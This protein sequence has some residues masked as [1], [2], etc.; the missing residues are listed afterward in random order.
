ML[1][2]SNQTNFQNLDVLVGELLKLPVIPLKDANS[3]RVKTKNTLTILQQE[4]AIFNKDLPF[5][6]VA[7]RGIETCVFVIFA[8]PDGKTLITHYDGVQGYDWNRYLSNYKHCE[9]SL[10]LIGGLENKGLENIKKVLKALQS[11]SQTNNLTFK[12]THQRV[13]DSFFLENS[14]KIYELNNYLLKKI[15]EALGHHLGKEL[16]EDCSDLVFPA[17]FQGTKLDIY[18]QLVIATKGVPFTHVPR[19][20]QTNNQ[21]WMQVQD[22]I[23][24]LLMLF[25]AVP[26]KVS[27]VDSEHPS[28]AVSKLLMKTPKLI[29]ML[30][31]M[32]FKDPIA[33]Q[34][35]R[36]FFEYAAGERRSY[37][38][39][40]ALSLKTGELCVLP[41][42]CSIGSSRLVRL[43]RTISTPL[44]TKAN[45]TYYDLNADGI[46]ENQQISETV[47]Q[48]LFRFV[49]HFELG[50]PYI[51]KSVSD[52]I[53]KDFVVAQGSA[54]FMHI[55][56]I[57][58]EVSRNEGFKEF[59][60]KPS[61]T[62]PAS[63]SSSSSSGSS[64]PAIKSS[65]FGT[66]QTSNQKTAQAAAPNSPDPSDS[67]F[68]ISKHTNFQW[69][70]LMLSEL[71]MLP[72]TPI[73]NINYH[74]VK[75]A[76]TLTILQ[77]ET[78]I[79]DQDSSF[80]F[81]ATRELSTCIFII[82]ALPDG[83]TLVTHYDGGKEYNWNQYLSAYKN[84]KINLQIVGGLESNGLLNIKKLLV[85][86][87]VLSK[88][89][90]L[91]FE[92]TQQRVQDNFYSEPSLL[93]YEINNFLLHKIRD[94][95]EYYFDS[96]LPENC[97]GL[98]F[99]QHFQD[100][101]V[102]VYGK[103]IQ[104]TAGSPYSNELIHRIRT[105]LPK[106][107]FTVF[108]K[109]LFD[110]R[111]KKG[112]ESEQEKAVDAKVKAMLKTPDNFLA[113]L[114]QRLFSSPLAFQTARI[115]FAYASGSDET[116]YSDVAVSLT[117]GK[118]CVPPHHQCSV[119]SNRLIRL[120]QPL[121]ARF[122]ARSNYV[123]YD[124]G[125]D[126]IPEASQVPTE[127]REMLFKYIPHF[128]QKNIPIPKAIY[129][130]IV[131]DF[132]FEDNSLASMAILSLF[133]EVSR[134]EGFKEFRQQP[135]PADSQ[136]STKEGKEESTAEDK[137]DSTVTAGGLGFSK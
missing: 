78:A 21:L 121:A 24:I 111:P 72:V 79:F 112:F 91:V 66:T 11:L 22:Q 123:Y 43:L 68:V 127:L 76:N 96:G 51:P 124:F 102:S 113:L 98:A 58:S 131:Q 15:E 64:N 67:M 23:G 5:E 114:K 133:A 33:Y 100:S 88:S 108:L 17:N 134:D 59:R 73:N 117:T 104:A 10:Q 53:V 105:V 29:E 136:S 28:D 60:Q 83:K 18:E 46:P 40:A 109:T 93:I 128:A 107:D 2:I 95:L 69:I 82:F 3:E 1:I 41:H 34:V 80:K 116:Y 13:Q 4:T 90:N 31:R 50:N 125:K 30:K 110:I 38:S 75:T 87:G 20:I 32:V 101:E 35:A 94:V 54:D 8:L 27:Q 39:S 89:H 137:A 63:S 106:E 19:V 122:R 48:M 119:G 115:F 71:L 14:S 62:L 47:R 130:A 7:T 37:Y 26:K 44:Q 126:G 65:F 129:N 81:V 49:P 92:I 99:P 42:H 70:D 103:L 120:L 84:S 74:I 97:E 25:T 52:A 9:I 135:A 6:F 36:L 16:P 55:L 77:Q 45:F 132:K 61:A 56:S 85:A 57:F 118:L 12:I 86:L